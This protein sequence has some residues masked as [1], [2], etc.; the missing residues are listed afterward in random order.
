MDQLDQDLQDLDFVIKR[1]EMHHASPPDAL[2]VA[3]GLR[4]VTKCLEDLVA[5]TREPGDTDQ[6]F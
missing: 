1:L 4:A 3:E 5:A 2:L 6:I